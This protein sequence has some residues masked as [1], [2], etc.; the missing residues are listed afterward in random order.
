MKFSLYSGLGY[1]MKNYGIEGTAKIAAE[2]G[3][4]GIEFCYF[5][6]GSDSLDIEG[7]KEYKKILDK[8]GLT[9]PCFTCAT[10]VVE[11]KKPDRINADN[12]RRLCEYLD[13]AATIG[14]PLFHHTVCY[15]TAP[16]KLNADFDSVL[17]LAVEGCKTV[18]DYAAR[19]GIKVIYE[20]QGFVFNGVSGLGALLERMKS[21][22]S[23][24]G[25]CGD[26]GNT[27][28]FD[29]FADGLF[30]KYPTDILHVHLKDMKLF[31]A[32]YDMGERRHYTTRGGQKAIEVEIGKGDIKLD[33]IFRTL[34]SVGYDGFY[35]IE[36]FKADSSY[37]ENV[38]SNQETIKREYYK[39]F[40]K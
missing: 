7:A 6:S 35:S 1:L 32:D 5:L 31:S 16:E 9:A 13:V 10:S 14:A 19:L 2:L 24:V 33:G 11:M 4:S 29:E 39:V 30:A 27:L 40:S 38:R 36:N 18:A 25:I 3:F 34:K 12:V 8:H 22:S 37:E 21:I 17:E 23:N 28:F 20:P 15:A 26:V